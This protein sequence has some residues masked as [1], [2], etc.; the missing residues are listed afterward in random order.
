MV[1]VVQR[2]RPP[3]FLR[4]APGSQPA[5]VRIW[6]PLHIPITKPPFRQKASTADMIGANRAIAPARK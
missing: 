1:T 2:K 5:S 3:L 6:N 4:K